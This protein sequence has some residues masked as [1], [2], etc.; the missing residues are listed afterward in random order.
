MVLEDH[1]LGFLLALLCCG[2][3]KTIERCGFPIILTVHLEV[4]ELSPNLEK[5][6]NLEI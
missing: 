2:Q 3:R 6:K 5:K 1:N 4:G